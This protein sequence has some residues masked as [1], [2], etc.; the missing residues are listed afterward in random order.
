[1]SVFA[2]YP[3]S[4]NTPS[5]AILYS[6][7]VFELK[8]VSDSTLELPF[9]DFATEFGINE[10][11]LLVCCRCCN[12]LMVSSEPIGLSVLWIMLTFEASCLRYIAAFRA[13]SPVPTILT[14]LFLK[15][16]HHKQHNKKLLSP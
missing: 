6:E 3:I 2:I 7:L 10:I 11:L 13:D 5:T 15:R 8:R 16:G 12:K 4:I 1:M 9:I 14:V